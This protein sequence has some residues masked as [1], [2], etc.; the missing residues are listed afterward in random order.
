MK[1]F[2]NYYTYDCGATIYIYEFF[3]FEGRSLFS[4]NISKGAYD[5]NGLGITIAGERSN[6]ILFGFTFGKNFYSFVL[7]SA[8]EDV[9]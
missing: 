2:R 6:P 3:V 5:E 9:N 8:R 4:F 1:L 7:F